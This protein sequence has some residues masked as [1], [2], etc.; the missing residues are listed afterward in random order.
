MLARP[1]YWSGTQRY[2]VSCRAHRCRIMCSTATP[3]ARRMSALHAACTVVGATTGCTTARADAHTWLADSRTNSS[4]ATSAPFRYRNTLPV[5]PAGAV[6]LWATRSA[7]MMCL[8]TIAPNPSAASSIANMH[9]L[10]VSL[11]TAVLLS[12]ITHIS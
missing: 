10:V 5:A 4:R 11:R 7:G 8:H 1:A 2:A 6:V 3:T 12:F 9:F